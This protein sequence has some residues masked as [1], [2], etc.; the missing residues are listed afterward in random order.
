MSTI[1][2]SS[3]TRT[4]PVG[5]INRGDLD[6]YAPKAREILDI[7]DNPVR[8]DTSPDDI[9]D[10]IGQSADFDHAEFWWSPPTRFG[11]KYRE[12]IE[13]NPNLDCYL[14]A[15]V[16]DIVLRENQSSVES[17]EIRDYSGRTFSFRTGTVILATGGIERVFN[18]RTCQPNIHNRSDV[19]A[20]S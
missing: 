9:E 14:N 3:H 16:V 2:R 18:G 7:V 19:L 4:I 13:S 15:N 5:P 17:L 8:W 10:A 1:S 6:T 12:P 20:L 11:Q